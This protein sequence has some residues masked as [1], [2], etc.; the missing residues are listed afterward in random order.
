MNIDLLKFD[1]EKTLAFIDK[2]DGYLFRVRNWGLVSCSGVLAFGIRQQSYL[3]LGMNLLLAAGILFIELIY[4]SFH[5]DAISK[6]TYLEEL[7]QHYQDESSIPKEYEFGI[8]HSIH[9]LH[10][11]DMAKILFNKK[12]WHI[13]VFYLSLA[14]VTAIAAI[15]IYTSQST[16]SKPGEINRNNARSPIG[17]PHYS[18]RA[19]AIFAS[20][21]GELSR[22]RRT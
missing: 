7:I 10:V 16:T 22:E 18:G 19:K 17:Y 6:S 20:A 11:G 9:P 5:E 13:W 14:I 1:Y 12:R 4:K 8:G 2:M 15:V 21:S 3:I